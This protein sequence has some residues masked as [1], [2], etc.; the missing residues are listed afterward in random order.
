MGRVRD[1]GRASPQALQGATP[2]SPRVQRAA[3]PTVPTGPRQQRR[4]GAWA[5]PSVPRLVSDADLTLAVRGDR[6]H[7]LSPVGVELDT[8]HVLA[9]HAEVARPP[10]VVEPAL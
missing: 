5:L 10:A 4:R 8:G 1:R 7:V 9:D 2:R 3:R 6:D